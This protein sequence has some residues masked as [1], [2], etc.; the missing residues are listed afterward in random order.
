MI[1]RGVGAN[2]LK[3]P[4]LALA[5]LARVLTDLP[6][7]PPLTEGEIVTTGTI[8][9]AWPVAPG[10]TWSSDYGAL[11]LEGTEACL[12]PGAPRRSPA[13]A[14][15][16]VVRTATPKRTRAL[17]GIRA[18]LKPRLEFDRI[19][20]R[21]IPNEPR[22]VESCSTQQRAQSRTNPSCSNGLQTVLSGIQ[23]N[24]SRA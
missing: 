3:S 6:Q 22:P 24:P 19:Q 23:T 11:G 10:E 12:P 15:G 16:G 9:D 5:H 18:T 8:T 13:R 17:A 20:L 4:A 7:F 1:D 2:V 14:A 21:R